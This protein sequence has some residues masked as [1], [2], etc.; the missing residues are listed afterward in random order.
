MLKIVKLLAENGYPTSIIESAR[1]QS[2]TCKRSKRCTK[3]AESILKLPF[4]HNRLAHDVRRAVRAFSKEVRVVFQRG[5]SLG[6]MLVSSSIVQPKCPREM[7][8]KKRG[9][10]DRQNVEHVMQVCLPGDV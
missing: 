4:V 7:S 8:R 5:Q 6:D 3:P 10:E 2:K 1:K 9:R